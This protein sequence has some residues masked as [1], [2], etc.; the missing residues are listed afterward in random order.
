[1]QTITARR[2]AFQHFICFIR[3]V[4]IVIII[5]MGIILIF[6]SCHKMGKTESHLLNVLIDADIKTEYGDN[7]QSAFREYVRKVKYSPEQYVFFNLSRFYNTVLGSGTFLGRL[8]IRPEDHVVSW[9]SSLSWIFP[10]VWQ[11]LLPKI[12]SHSHSRLTPLP[13]RCGEPS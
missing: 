7:E 9:S 1:M 3:F 5:I 12:P 8:T 11:A 4:T 10:P 2:Y 13:P 6:Q